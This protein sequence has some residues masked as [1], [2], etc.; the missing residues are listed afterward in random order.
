VHTDI[1]FEESPAGVSKLDPPVHSLHPPPPP[2]TQRESVAGIGA[3]SGGACFAFFPPPMSCCLDPRHVL[4]LAQIFA[5]ASPDQAQ[6]GPVSLAAFRVMN[7][8]LHGSASARRACEAKAKL[9]LA[10]GEI[11]KKKPP[12]CQQLPEIL[13]VFSREAAADAQMLFQKRCSSL[14]PSPQLPKAHWHQGRARA[15]LAGQL[16]PF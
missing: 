16:Q 4:E 1:N 8:G 14:A 5:F 7:T 10:F 6:M 13:L 11:A 2:L 15:R 3:A 12:R 9:E